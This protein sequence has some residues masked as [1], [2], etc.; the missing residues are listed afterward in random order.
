MHARVVENVSKAT[1]NKE[2]NENQSPER[3]DSAKSSPCYSAFPPHRHNKNTLAG[4]E[5]VA[6]NFRRSWEGGS[7]SEE[8]IGTVA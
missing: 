7:E 4:T 3:N 1:G 6:V 2:S 5:F 8:E